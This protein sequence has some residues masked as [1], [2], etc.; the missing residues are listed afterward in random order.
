MAI[1][2]IE[3]KQARRNL[4]NGGATL[5]TP[6]V[7]REQSYLFVSEG[8][9]LQQPVS[10]PQCL[11]KGS[12]KPSSHGIANNNSVNHKAD[13]M[14]VSFFQLRQIIQFNDLAIQAGPRKSCNDASSNICRCSPLR[15][16]MT[17]AMIISFVP[18]G[19]CMMASAICNGDC[20]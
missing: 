18:A 3:G 14:F 19:Y 2:R 20:F 1:R 16:R 5:R 13:V 12:F 4:C 6:E 15:P 11:V 8:L 10:P 17:G 7:F 9:D